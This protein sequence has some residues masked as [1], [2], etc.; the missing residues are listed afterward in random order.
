MVDCE[1]TWLMVYLR[2]GGKGAG[3]TADCEL[4]A[5]RP[6]LRCSKLIYIYL[7]HKCGDDQRER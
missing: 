7:Q 4:F 5:L 1:S 3:R 2:K 6:D